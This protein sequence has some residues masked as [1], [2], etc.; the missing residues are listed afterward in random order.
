MSATSAEFYSS[1]RYQDYW[2]YIAVHITGSDGVNSRVPHVFLWIVHSCTS[3]FIGAQVDVEVTDKALMLV[4]D[5]ARSVPIET[6]AEALQTLV[7]RGTTLPPRAEPLKAQPYNRATYEEEQALQSVQQQR[8]AM[9]APAR[10]LPSNSL[11]PPTTAANSRQ[12]YQPLPARGAS[13][14]E[15]YPMVRAAVCL[16]FL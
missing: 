2:R 8:R 6:F 16:L 10:V 1:V 15:S 4:E 9:L 5:W 12:Q 3:T 13:L 11:P 7:Q 14:P